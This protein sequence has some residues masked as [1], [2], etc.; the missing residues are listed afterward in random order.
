ML[1]RSHAEI[2]EAKGTN[3]YRQSVAELHDALWAMLMIHLLTHRAERVRRHDDAEERRLL[4][5]VDHDQSVV[6][7]PERDRVEGCST[8]EATWVHREEEFGM[9]DGRDERVAGASWPAKNE[10]H[11]KKLVAA[12]F[13]CLDEVGLASVPEGA[14]SSHASCGAITRFPAS[15]SAN[16]TSSKLAGRGRNGDIGVQASRRSGR[17]FDTVS[18]QRRPRGSVSTNRMGKRN[19]SGFAMR[20]TRYN[21]SRTTIV[22]NVDGVMRPYLRRLN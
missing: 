16:A 13:D 9:I 8:T 7:N 21:T 19:H 10:P 6:L 5:G 20:S 1:G 11:W 4:G 3:V 2:A 18:T 15:S 14:P 17:S 12:P 22:G